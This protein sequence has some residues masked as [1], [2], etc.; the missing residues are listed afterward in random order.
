MLPNFFLAGAPKA[1]TTSLY[2]YLDQHP[3]VFMSPIK[4]PNYFASEIRAENFSEELQVKIRRDFE[5]LRQYLDGP[6]SEKRF[7]ALGLEWEDY[8]KLFRNARGEKAIGEASVCYLWSESAARNI[9]AR[10]PNARILMIL[11]DPAERAFS[12]YM[13]W[14]TKGVIGCSFREQVEKSLR[15]AGGKFQLM[16][17]FLEMGLYYEQVKRYLE[18]FPRGNIHIRLYEDRQGV[19]DVLRFLDVDA[20]FVP[21]MSRRH[22]TGRVPASTMDA[23]DRAYLAGY[24]REDI[25]RLAGLLDRDL[26]RWLS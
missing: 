25:R 4:E 15:S 20:E 3:Q 24:Y 2:H 14:V 13:Q 1:G 17:P 16:Q 7:G 6:M 23:A 19:A 9:F 22:L 12:Q 18:L 21:D 10:V 8:L 11:R 5:E 26:A